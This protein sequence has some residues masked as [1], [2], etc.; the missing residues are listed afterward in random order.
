MATD[1]VSVSRMRRTTG[2]WRFAPWVS[3]L[4]L[5]L[6]T[7]IMI[8]ASVHYIMDPTHAASPTGVALTTP[9]ALTDTRVV[10]G[11]T[12]TMVFILAWA[13]FSRERLRLGHAVVI[14][15]MALVLAVRMFGFLRDGTTLETGT[16]KVKTRGEI[17]FLVLNAAGFALQTY[18]RKPMEVSR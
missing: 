17:V 15:L 11:I 2:A 9:E 4:V 1:A 8:V 13:I 5:I 7:L 14:G 6:P 10:G 12:L 3:R 18:S 16:Q